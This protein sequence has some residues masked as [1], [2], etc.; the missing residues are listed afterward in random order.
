MAACASGSIVIIAGLS[1]VAMDQSSVFGR[2]F[3]LERT[4]RIQPDAESTTGAGCTDLPPGTVTEA[5]T[6]VYTV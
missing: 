4:R 1:M 6:M 2:A 3:I 5:L